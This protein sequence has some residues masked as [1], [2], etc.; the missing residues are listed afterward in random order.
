MRGVLLGLI[1]TFGVLLSGCQDNFTFN[2]S[3][4]EPLLSPNRFLNIAHRGASGHAPEHTMPAY[5]LGVKMNGDY[6]EIDLQLTRDG[7]LIAMHDDYI[8]RIT[9]YSG[10]V[11][12]FTLEELKQLDIGSW[13]NH[14]YPHRAKSDYHQLQVLTLDEIIDN[15]GRD[16]NYYIEIKKTKYVD[17]IIDKLLETLRKYDLIHNQARKGQVVIQSF[18][19]EYLQKINE[20]EPS[21]PLIQLIRYRKRATINE[22]QLH[23]IK[24]YA[25]GI[26]LNH[27]RL[28]RRYVQKVREAGLLIH[29]YTV[30]R[31]ARMKKLI[32]WGVTGIFTDFPDRLDEVLKE[33]KAEEG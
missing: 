5:E 22:D 24:N 33:L 12:S 20:I 16:L 26:G 11:D 28:S 10:K 13:F 29:P 19:P 1:L 7:H 14:K 25:V 27:K 2:F 4:D 8:D 3:E 18:H 30:N 15:F 9:D 6:L 32:R 23:T 31:K 21:I 17:Q